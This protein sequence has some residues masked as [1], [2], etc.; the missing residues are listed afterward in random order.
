MENLNKEQIL[1]VLKDPKCEDKLLS[2]YGDVYTETNWQKEV[3]KSKARFKVIAAGRRSGKTFYAALNPSDGLIRDFLTPDSYT[4]IIAP[5]YDLTQRVWSLFLRVALQ[6]FGPLV[7]NLQNSQGRYRIESIFN[8][9]IE[10]KTAEDPKKLVGVGLTHLIMDEC[11]EIGSEVWMQTRPALM[12]KK[13]KALF[14]GRAQGKNWFADEWDRGQKD[15]PEYSPEYESWKFS[16]FDNNLLKADEIRSASVQLSERKMRE[17]IYSDFIEGE[18]T[19]FQ[20]IKKRIAGALLPPDPRGSYIMGID[21]GRKFSDT[22]VVIINENTRHVDYFETIEDTDWQ[23]QTNKIKKIYEQYGSPITWCDSSGIGDQFIEGLESV[24]VTVEPYVFSRV[25]KP[26]LI[27]KLIVF[28]EK[29]WISY[30]EI[31]RLIKEFERFTFKKSDLGQFRYYSSYKTDA[32]MALALAVHAVEEPIDAEI[33]CSFCQYPIKV[34][35]ENCPN[36]FAPVE[37][38]SRSRIITF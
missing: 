27:E 32:I 14:I 11:G 36:C 4:W 17:E 19:V 3:R 7:G 5:T 20:D 23:I 29:G 16:S 35:R 13:G 10:A 22:V 15:N 34:W 8:S 31:P 21:L 18:G 38:T 25:S 28:M 12:D 2:I 33:S 9:V 26:P 24:G 37:K 30:P 1:E 6:R